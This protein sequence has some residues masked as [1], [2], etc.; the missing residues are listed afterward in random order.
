M[1]WRLE[2]WTAVL[3]LFSI[4]CSAFAPPVAARRPPASVISCSAFAPPVA[5]RRPPAAPAARAGRT[6]PWM[7]AGPNQNQNQYFLEKTGP[8]PV[9]ADK[10]AHGA[11]LAVQAAPLFLGGERVASLA[12]FWTTA[13]LAVYLGG[14]R[15]KPDEVAELSLKSAALAPVISSISLGGLYLILKYTEFD[16]GYVYRLFTCLFAFLSVQEIASDALDVLLPDAV[17]QTVAV[18]L[19]KNGLA[20]VESSSDGGEEVD[21]VL[22]GEEIVATALSAA[23]V[24]AYLAGAPADTVVI[25]NAIGLSIAVATLPILNLR[26]FSIASAFLIGLFCYDV[27]WVFG[28][29]VMMTVAT[30]IEAPVKFIFPNGK[31]EGYPFSVLGLGDVVIPGAFVSLMREVDQQAKARLLGP[32]SS[33]VSGSGVDA[34]SHELKLGFDDSPYF[35]SALAAYG[36]GLGLTF[37]ANEV[38]KAGQPALFYL[39]PCVIGSALLTAALRSE[40][41]VLF[42]FGARG[43]GCPVPLPPT[44]TTPTPMPVLTPPRAPAARSDLPTQTPAAASPRTHPDHSRV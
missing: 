30:K 10:L 11:V 42:D 44:T 26:S 23:L 28:T 33:E 31:V 14:V 40:L 29:D 13:C 3:L 39:V 15:P 41:G 17:K 6:G 21:A 32:N 12:Y 37:V 4:P 36:F 35:T 22:G 16:P 19:G 8:N 38:T 1:A 2:T 20:I 27:F 25:S 43:V 34:R 18:D 9:A 7:A 5:A 24:G